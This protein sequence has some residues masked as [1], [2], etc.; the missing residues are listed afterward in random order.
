MSLRLFEPSLGEVPR[1]LWHLYSLD[2][3]RG[4]YRLTCDLDAHVAGLKRAL[5]TE[6]VTVKEQ[7]LLITELRQRVGVIPAACD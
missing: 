5:A 3:E 1:K 6:R 4:G 7:R 2:A